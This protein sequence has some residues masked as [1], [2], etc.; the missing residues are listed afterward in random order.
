M[1]YVGRI[2]NVFVQCAHTPANGILRIEMERVTMAMATWDDYLTLTSRRRR[3]AVFDCRGDYITISSSRCSQLVAR[4]TQCQMTDS[5]LLLY[6]AVLPV[7]LSPLLGSFGSVDSWDIHHRWM[8]WVRK[9]TQSHRTCFTLHSYWNVIVDFPSL[10]RSAARTVATQRQTIAHKRRKFIV[11]P[12]ADSGNFFFSFRILMSIEIYLYFVPWATVAGCVGLRQRQNETTNTNIFR[13]I[14]FS[15]IV[16]GTAVGC[17]VMKTII[18]R[19]TGINVF[20]VSK[21]KVR[22]ATVQQL[23][24]IQEINR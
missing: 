2:N 17:L 23:A 7:V 12:A 15:I 10:S 3:Y 18:D 19:T 16:N 6:C 5:F 8:E 11:S 22:S 14:F 1:S 13:N 20:T 9:S 4:S 24:R 21:C